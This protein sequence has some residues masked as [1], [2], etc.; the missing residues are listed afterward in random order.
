MILVL[1][2]KSL[3]KHLDDRITNNDIIGFTETQVIPS[4]STCKI[5]GTLNFFTFYF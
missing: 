2:V 1:N 5:T 4:N 3:S